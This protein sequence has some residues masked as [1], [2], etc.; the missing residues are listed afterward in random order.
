MSL[1]RFERALL[2]AVLVEKAIAFLDHGFQIFINRIDPAG[3]MH[4]SGAVVEA[5]IDEELAPGRCAI[6]IQPFVAHHL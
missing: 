6:G 4:P 2:G 3:S 5:L 1:D